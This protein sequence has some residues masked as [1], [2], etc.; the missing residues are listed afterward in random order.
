MMFRNLVAWFRRKREARAAAVMF[1][2]K[3]IVDFNEEGISAAYPDG[4]TQAIAW[5]A[6]E[7]LAIVTND[8][9]PWDTDVW[10]LIEGKETRCAYP[11]GATGDSAALEEYQRRFPGFSDIA[12]IEAMGSTSNAR[13]VCWERSA[14]L[15]TYQ[16]GEKPRPLA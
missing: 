9:G 8:S 12:V 16:A 7:C 14:Q 1:E 5:S 15:Q 4:V 11:Q 2:R 6:V 10:W 3:V 13:F